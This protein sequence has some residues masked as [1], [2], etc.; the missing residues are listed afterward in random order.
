M[1]SNYRKLLVKMLQGDDAEWALGQMSN[2]AIWD[3]LDTIQSS[4]ASLSSDRLQAIM[5]SL[6]LGKVKAS[7]IAAKLDLL[8]AAGVDDDAIV[9]I[10]AKRNL[11]LATADQLLRREVADKPTLLKLL[12][13]GSF[14]PSIDGQAMLDEWGVGINDLLLAQES[15]VDTQAMFDWYESRD[16]DMALLLDKSTPELRRVAK[17]R[18]DNDDTTESSDDE[19]QSVRCQLG[20]RE[21]KLKALKATKQAIDHGSLE[22]ARIC[23]GDLVDRYGFSG[24]HITQIVQTID[25]DIS[26]DTAQYLI[27]HC[28]ADPSVVAEH[29]SPRDVMRSYAWLRRNGVNIDAAAAYDRLDLVGKV[30]CAGWAYANGVKID[31]NG[32]LQELCDHRPTFEMKGDDGKEV[33][34]PYCVRRPDILLRLPCIDRRIML[35]VLS[36][37]DILT[38][39][40][41]LMCCCRKR[42]GQG[43][44]AYAS[45]AD[46]VN[47]L[48]SSF[49]AEHL[50]DIIELACNK[51]DMALVMAK[52]T[53]AQLNKSISYLLRANAPVERVASRIWPKTAIRKYVNLKRAG[54]SDKGLWQMM[55]G[56]PVKSA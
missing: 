35:G 12:C 23:C 13:S 52:L 22:L 43:S 32:D 51:G 27:E 56:Q 48:S 42:R 33:L 31:I 14:N 25:S 15:L 34:V 10:C 3:N 9:A 8:K 47:A 38:Y 26:L 30:E 1:V 37:D 36:E 20:P 46:I 6:P 7:D 49:I 4:H 28:G 11:D 18:E 50:V 24:T 41:E 44:G 53:D 54:F 39:S 45:Y 29:M 16:A 55:N 21:R 5:D 19:S 40:H 2:V 17:A